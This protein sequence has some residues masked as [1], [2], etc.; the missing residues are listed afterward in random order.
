MSFY[1]A[2][3]AVVVNAE[4]EVVEVDASRGVQEKLTFVN[5]C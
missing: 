5:V 1:V 4:L 2:L 3:F